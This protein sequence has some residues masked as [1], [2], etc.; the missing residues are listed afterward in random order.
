MSVD[1]CAKQNPCQNG[2]ECE[3]KGNEYSCK[4]KDGFQGKNCEN[5]E[6]KTLYLTLLPISKVKA[7]TC[8]N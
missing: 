1:L 5:G 4:C 7:N 8:F 6:K 3:N 2:A